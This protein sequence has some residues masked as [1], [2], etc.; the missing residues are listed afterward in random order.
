[1]SLV[2]FSNLVAKWLGDD[3]V[4][5]TLLS[6]TFV[7]EAA[8]AVGILLESKFK[9]CKD[10][11]SAILVVGGVCLGVFFTLVLFAY[12]E[13]ISAGQKLEIAQLKVQAAQL[14]ER[15]KEAERAAAEAELQSAKLKAPRTIRPEQAI[16]LIEK[17]RPYAGKKFWIITQTTKDS[18]WSEQD[19]LAKQL[20]DIFLAASWIKD[21][22]PYVDPTKEES[23]T[24][25]VSDRG[26]LISSSDDSFG[27]L[28]AT[29]LK[30]AAD[31][32]C[33]HTP[34]AGMAPDF[35]IVEIGLH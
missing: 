17:L 23:A 34:S 8:V 10:W 7:A 3:A 12:D 35:A 2:Y 18:I 27:L 33:L 32:E 22:H 25:G 6:G 15:A 11:A 30:G 29:I 4:H 31:I 20:S 1:M 13:D 24:E 28:V 9:T 26:C 21:S 14:N 19:N 16:A 5:P